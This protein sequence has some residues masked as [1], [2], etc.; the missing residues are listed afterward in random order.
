MR[1]A[2]ANALKLLL[3]RSVVNSCRHTVLEFYTLLR[4]FIKSQDASYATIGGE[5]DE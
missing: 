1:I 5:I 2:L 4:I 3:L